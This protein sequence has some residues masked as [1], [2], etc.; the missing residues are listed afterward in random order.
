MAPGEI[1]SLPAYPL[2]LHPRKEAL[3][4]SLERRGKRYV[5]LCLGL[6][7]AAGGIRH[8]HCTYDGPFWETWEDGVNFFGEP[9]RQVSLNILSPDDLSSAQRVLRA[10][11]SHACVA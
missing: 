8:D 2:D 7:E 10:R 11:L 3:Q 1:R 4:K 6:P 9:T 5:E